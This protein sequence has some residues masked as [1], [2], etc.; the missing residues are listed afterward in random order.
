MTS[1]TCID[2]KGQK[3][4]LPDSDAESIKES[5]EEEEED[6]E[7]DTDPDEFVEDDDSWLVNDKPEDNQ[8]HSLGEI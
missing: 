6:E 5:D 7:M 1:A 8:P 4:D 3:R 2:R